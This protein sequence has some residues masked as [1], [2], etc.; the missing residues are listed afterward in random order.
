MWRDARQSAVDAAEAVR[1][2]LAALGLPEA[3]WS[4][5]RP[6]VTASGRPLVHLGALP[7]AAVEV[8]AK[9]LMP[10]EA[11][12]HPDDDRIQMRWLDTGSGPGAMVPVL[13][14]DDRDLGSP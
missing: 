12:P 2:A 7:A 6:M 9:A 10:G 4:G 13:V 11:R 14:T 5:V 3:A 1:A 8:T